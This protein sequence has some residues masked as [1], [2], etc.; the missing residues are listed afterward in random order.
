MVNGAAPYHPTLATYLATSDGIL[1]IIF[2]LS[3]TNMCHF[4]S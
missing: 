3:C 2:K 4:S 1:K